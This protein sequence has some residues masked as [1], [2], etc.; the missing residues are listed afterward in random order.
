M[1]DSRFPVIPAKA[2]MTTEARERYLTEW[3][4]FSVLQIRYSVMTLT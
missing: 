3:G 1:D 4:N 2:G